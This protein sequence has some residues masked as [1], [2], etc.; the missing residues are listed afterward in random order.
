MTKASIMMDDIEVTTEG[1]RESVKQESAPPPRWTQEYTDWSESNS[2][3]TSDDSSFAASN[4][5][6][7]R[8]PRKRGLLICMFMVLLAAIVAGI[9][10]AVLMPSN[11]KRSTNVAAGTAGDT[12]IPQSTSAPTAA[13][14]L[15]EEC[16]PDYNNVDYCLKNELTEAQAD[17]CVDCVWAFL[18]NNSGP[19]QQL[20]ASIC[21]VLSQCECG[22]CSAFLENYLDCQSSC[23]FDCQLDSATARAEGVPS[24]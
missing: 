5:N 3:W 10:V 22:A 23:E 7:S 21:N 24:G 19:C 16:V 6:T 15:P 14:P 12:D 1:V 20:E 17:D 13:P 9:V 11:N 4:N 8:R 2:E 18:P